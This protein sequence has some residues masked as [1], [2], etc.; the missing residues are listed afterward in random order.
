MLWTVRHRFPGGA[1]FDFNYY[2]HRIKLLVHS[3]REL[4]REALLIREG[5][6]QGDPISMFINEMRFSVLTEKVRGE[7]PVL[8]Q[9]W[10]LK[11][12]K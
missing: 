5:V 2:I 9:S 7:Y 8:I 6:N 4:E 1:H 11:L 3:P 12:E 10:Y